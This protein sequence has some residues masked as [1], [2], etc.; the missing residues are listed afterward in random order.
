MGKTLRSKVCVKNANISVL[1]YITNIYLYSKH[2]SSVYH[3]FSFS[4]HSAEIARN[5]S[6]QTPLGHNPPAAALFSASKKTYLRRQ[7]HSE[8]HNIVDIRGNVHAMGEREREFYL[9]P[10]QPGFGH[11]AADTAESSERSMSVFSAWQV[12]VQVGRRPFYLCYK[13]ISVV[14]LYSRLLHCGPK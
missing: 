14:Y 3:E 11:K 1:S 13:I 8:V 6:G 9:T 10:N 12:Y 2:N 4:L 5:D 7:K